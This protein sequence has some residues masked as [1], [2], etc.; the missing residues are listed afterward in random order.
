MYLNGRV[1]IVTGASKEIGAAMAE[2]LAREGAAVVAH[3]ASDP[4]PAEQV[5]QR[6]REGGGRAIA[7]GAD[8]SKVADNYALVNAAVQAFGRLDIFV[9]NAGISKFGRLLDFSEETFETMVGLN[10]KGS[11]FG[12]QAAAK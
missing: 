2:A 11:Y 6:I 9:A 8:C 12:A 7:F 3:F 1:A 10:F 4:E 5:A